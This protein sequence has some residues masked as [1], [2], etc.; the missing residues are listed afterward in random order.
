ML[1]RRVGAWIGVA[2]AI[3]AIAIAGIAV[4]GL[5]LGVEFTGGRLLEFSTTEEVGVEEARSAVADAGFPS[6]VVQASGSG[7]TAS[8][9]VRTSDVDND[10][11]AAI[12]QSLAEVAGAVTK[13]RDELI[14]ATL[15]EELRTKAL[16]AF[17]IA[18]GTQMLYL[19]F[20]FRW[21][22]A[23]A[24][25]ASMASVVLA[26]VG[27]FA[28]LGKPIDGVFLAAVLSIIGLAGNDTI[29]VFDRIRERTRGKVDRL[30]ETVNQAILETVPR[31]LNTGLGAM[32]ILAALAV[33]GGESLE[34]FAIALLV[35]L[36]LGVYS[37]VFTAA[38]LAIWAEER[39]PSPEPS[40]DRVVDPYAAVP[41]GGRTD[42]P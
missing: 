20:R 38:P 35:G 3:A 40:S 25:V 4:R 29:V 15:G 31:T 27:L 19:A 1:M 36:T 26:V 14:G 10:E 37:T 5:N 2:V 9:T 8:L 21:T 12:E 18:I 17:A 42:G 7:D 28:W 32:F 11:A 22:Y 13:E 33:V 24:A 41:V 34:D 30:R 16:I 6:A 39:W 23:A